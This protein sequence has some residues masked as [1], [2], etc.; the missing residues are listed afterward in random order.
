MGNNNTVPLDR[1]FEQMLISAERYACGRQ[2]Y[3]VSDTIQYITALLP[4]LSDW[5]IT[6]I[7]NDMKAKSDMAERLSGDPSGSSPWGSPID[8]S[9]WMAF[10]EKCKKEMERRKA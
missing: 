6:I 1:N 10:W 3:I 2:T 9:E 7:L 4:Y 5:C 8:K